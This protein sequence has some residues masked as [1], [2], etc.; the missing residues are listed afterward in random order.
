MRTQVTVIIHIRKDNPPPVQERY[1]QAGKAAE[2]IEM[3]TH[4]SH[5]RLF[6]IDLEKEPDEL[7]DG[8]AEAIV[9]VVNKFRRPRS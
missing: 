5:E 9:E 2:K 7:M 8:L 1:P 6:V 4:V 3:E